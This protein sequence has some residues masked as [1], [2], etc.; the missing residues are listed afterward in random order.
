MKR[1]QHVPSAAD[2]RRGL[3]RLVMPRIGQHGAHSRRPRH[4]RTEEGGIR[5]HW[6][7]IVLFAGAFVL[8]SSTAAIAYVATPGS[9]TGTA[10][11]VTL[12][13]AG[14]GTAASPTATSLALSW[15]ASPGLPSGGG[16]LVLRSTT[17]AGPYAKVSSGT[18]NQAITL[19]SAATS[20][21]D[22]GLTA[23][24]TYYYEVEAGYYDVSSLWVSAPDSQ[25]SGVTSQASSGPASTGAPVAAGPSNPTSPGPVITSSSSTSFYVGTAGTFQVAASGS[26]APTYSNTAFIGCAPS[27]LPTGV[28]FSSTGLL[29]GTPAAD[30]A[31]TYT[32]CITAS[33]AAH[34][35][36]TQKFTLTVATENLVITSPAVSGA[37]SSTS[38]LGPITV[39]RRTG[40]GAPITTG[41]ALTVNL[42]SSAGDATFGSTQFST[43]PLTSV[44]IPSGQST[45]TFWYGANAPGTPTITA[46]AQGYVVGTQ[47][48]TIT[49]A[50]AGLGIVPGPGSTGSPVN[51]C[52]TPSASSTCTVTGVGPSGQVVVAVTFWDAGQNPV[53]YSTTQA[54]AVD[55]TGAITGAVTIERGV[56]RVEPQDAH[57]VRGDFD[58]DLRPLHVDDRRQRMTVCRDGR[59]FFSVLTCNVSLAWPGP[60]ASART[61]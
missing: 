16:Y 37:T 2:R 55:E 8:A 1:E 18:C 15:G 34:A 40:S 42:T 22:T 58:A 53:V 10:Q 30:A 5:R 27:T 17:S 9:G 59:S 57:R 6:V 33:T 3:G 41:G 49:T 19:V 24:T 60:A 4:V 35:T 43:A 11:A 45:G 13:T 36:S 54:S 39:A 21:T 50:P 23:G 46:S 32:L 56:I 20:C 38:N 31:G 28:S 52:G 25:F 51:S 12:N 61:V 29:S 44:T 48:E 14:A 7:P 47:Q 26:P